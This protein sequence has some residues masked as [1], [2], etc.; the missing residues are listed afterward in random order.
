MMNSKKAIKPQWQIN[1][2][3]GLGLDPYNWKLYRR[4]PKEDGKGYTTWKVD[5]Y[6]P[7][8]KFLGRGLQSSILLTSSN[9]DSFKDHLA[10]AVKAAEDAVKALEVQMERI[11]VGLD[12]MPP[13]YADYALMQKT[14]DD[15]NGKR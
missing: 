7:N 8:L 10:E 2:E 14:G 12:T 3:W 9:I 15:E 13:K 11:G 1:E 4:S 5:S 6:Y